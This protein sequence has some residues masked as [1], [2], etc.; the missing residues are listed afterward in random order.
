M[1]ENTLKGDDRAPPQPAAGYV[2]E[3][4]NDLRP[5]CLFCNGDSEAETWANSTVRSSAEKQTSE[6]NSE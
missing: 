3:D 1:R 2:T 5:F 4:A 6:H